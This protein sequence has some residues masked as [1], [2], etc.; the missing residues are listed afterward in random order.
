MND[1]NGL[2]FAF[3]DVRLS[4]RQCDYISSAL[5][6]AADL[7]SAGRRLLSHPTIL[8]LLRH[9]QLGG[10]LRAF[11]GREL[12]AVAARLVVHAVASDPVV[13]WHQNRVVAVRERMDVHGYGPW[14]TL[15]GVPHVEAP[16]SVLK[17][18]IALRIQLD[19]TP[20]GN[21]EFHVLPGS[22]RAGKLTPE[23]IEQLTA[24]VTPLTLSLPKGS[25]LLMNPLLVHSVATGAQPSHC[26]VLQ[27]EFAPVEAIS[28]LQWSS[29]VQ[30]H[31]A[32]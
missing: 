27:V 10:C 18:M 11:T 17:Q 9:Q 28:P 12:V 31:H 20:A 25:L 8:A 3:A 7:R 14:T 19:T 2:G 30:L 4:E 22:H 26:R 32:A 23:Q 29:A 16:S 1:L 21:P 15:L 24:T 5:P 6:S 13:Q